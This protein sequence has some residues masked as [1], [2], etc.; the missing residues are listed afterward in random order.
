[1]LHVREEQFSLLIFLVSMKS[2]NCSTH[3]LRLSP[4]TGWAGIQVH[5]I[6][7]YTQLSLTKVTVSVISLLLWSISP[8]IPSS[9]LS[10]SPNPFPHRSYLAGS[11]VSGPSSDRSPWRFTRE[12]EIAV[13]GC[14]WWIGVVV[15]WSWLG[16]WA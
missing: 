8:S 12:V 4:V 15:K 7:F 3:L 5:R 11:W 13:T 14:S 10:Q 2:L 9:P 16:D 1:M 6:W